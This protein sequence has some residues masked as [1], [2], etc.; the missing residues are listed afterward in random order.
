[1]REK[2]FELVALVD[3]DPKELYQKHVDEI[4]VAK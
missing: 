3:A 2:L 1:M 4:A